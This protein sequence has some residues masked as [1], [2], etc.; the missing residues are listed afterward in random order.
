MI[1]LNW[2][3]GVGLATL[4]LVYAGH[5]LARRSHPSSLLDKLDDLASGN[6]RLS[7]RI[8]NSILVPVLAAITVVIFWPVAAWLK[9]MDIWILRRRS[10]TAHREFAVERDHL[11]RPLSLN[12][13]EAREVVSDPLGAVSELPFGHLNAAWS[14]FLGH[15]SPGDELWS[16]NARCR[17][18]WGRTEFRSGYVL[19]RDSQP[20]PYFLTVLMDLQD[21]G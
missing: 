14:S 7:Y 19:V 15:R 6:K 1:W 11:E 4:V 3:L 18:A 12:E 16:F 20:G 5:R 13:V 9:I 17:T 21:L 10:S 2:Y 8:L